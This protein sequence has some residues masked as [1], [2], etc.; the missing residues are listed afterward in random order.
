LRIGG[1]R[2]LAG[3]FAALFPLPSKAE[4]ASERRA[5]P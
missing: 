2:A 3:R 1:D 4:R 5:A